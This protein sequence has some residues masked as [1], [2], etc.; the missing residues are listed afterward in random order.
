MALMGG[1]DA[2]TG[3][4]EDVEVTNKSFH[5]VEQGVVGGERNPDSTTNNYAATHEEANYSVVTLVD[6]STTVTASPCYVY[7]WHANSAVGT[8]TLIK[9]GTTTV[10]TQA[11]MSAGDTVTL[12]A[13]IRFETSLVVDPDNAETATDF[14]IFWRPI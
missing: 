12:P 7:G 5:A 11:A 13:A 4:V 10:F 8:V 1:L 3:K 14:T 6:D 2:T 9:D